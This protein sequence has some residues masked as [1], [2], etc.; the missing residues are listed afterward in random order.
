[1]DEDLD[2]LQTV[3]ERQS[4]RHGEFTLTSGQKSHYYCDTKATVLSPRGATL[5]GELLHRLLRSHD[6]EAVGGMAI[7]AAYLATAVAIASER[8]DDPIYGFVVRPAAKGH[9]TE[10]RIDAS[11]HPDGQPLI[12]PGRRVAVVDDVVT[13]AG[14]ILR[15]IEVVQ[16]AGCQV[17]AAAAVLDRQAG[18]GERIRDLGI[19]FAALLLADERGLLR[20]GP[21]LP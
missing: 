10:S 16:E 1:M 5:C 8:A 11:W 12:T 4:I 21:N 2:Q 14:S 9:G 7:G 20:P 18:G 17:V 6:V 19:P 13:T 3:L 15:A